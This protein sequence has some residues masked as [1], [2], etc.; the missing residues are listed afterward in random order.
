MVSRARADGGRSDGGR[1]HL[2]RPQQLRLTALVPLLALGLW[3]GCGFGD[4]TTLSR[5]RKALVVG[6]VDRAR[7]LVSGSDAVPADLSRVLVS[8]VELDGE[9]GA[10]WSV[11]AGPILDAVSGAY[12]RAR[13]DERAAIDSY[14]SDRQLRRTR[15]AAAA[16]DFAVERLVIWL[17]GA[18]EGEL[19][20]D[21][22]TAV[23]VALLATR[24]LDPA[25]ARRA[26]VI[27]TR[28]GRAATAPLAAAVS[29]DD[30]L[31]RASAV[32][33]LSDLGTDAALAAILPLI[34]TE[35][36]F[37]PLYEM[38]MALGRFGPG[39]AADPR[40]ALLALRDDSSHAT[41]S[42]PARALAMAQLGRVLRAAPETRA[43]GIPVVI[44]GL[45]DEHLYVRTRAASILTELRH[46]AVAQ[47]LA[48]L[49]GGWHDHPLPVV[50]LLQPSVEAEARVAL[51]KV[52]SETLMTLAEPTVMAPGERDGLVAAL[53]EALADEVRRPIAVGA[54][55]GLGPAGAEALYPLLDSTDAGVRALV[56]ETLAGMGEDAS[57]ARIV[58][59]ITREAEAEPLTAMIAALGALDGAAVVATV[60]GLVDAAQ[61]R[62]DVLEAVATAL[63]NALEGG[64]DAA[65]VAST[66]NVLLVTAT[67]DSARE[68]LRR[69]AIRALALLAPDGVENAM[70]DIMLSEHATPLIRKSAAAALTSL[71]SR[72][73][74]ALGAMEEILHIRRE[75]PD[76]FLKRLRKRHGSEAALN[77]AWGQMGWQTG[78]GN[79]RE[80][81]V[82]P[83]ILRAEV[84]RSVHTLRGA[85]AADLLA[86]VL[87]DDQSASVR[88]AAASRL[89]GAPA[90]VDALL[91]ALRKDDSGTVRAAC[92]V[93]L[94]EM[95]DAR[96]EGALLR[97]VVRDDYEQA[98][99]QAAIA[100]GVLGGAHAAKELSALLIADEDDEDDQLTAALTGDIAHALAAIGDAATPHLLP[101]LRHV[102][103]NVRHAVVRVLATSSLPTASAALRTVLRDDPSA[104]VRQAAAAHGPLMSAEAIDALISVVGNTEEWGAVRAEAADS[105]GRLGV[106]KAE[107]TLEAGLADAI[108]QVRAACATALGELH[109]DEAAGPLAKLAQNTS[110]L[111]LV[112]VAAVQA[113]GALGDVAEP[114]LLRLAAEEV[115][116][117][118][119]AAVTALTGFG[120]P[121]ASEALAAIAASPVEPRALRNIATGN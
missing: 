25:I 63:A 8:A 11:T 71:G 99:R 85:R 66:V 13:S 32:R 74:I 20:S 56:A 36:E 107:G 120:S 23:D 53:Q 27:V 40:A 35:T 33:W 67:S 16:A 82:I 95:G 15:A 101:G 109:S 34:G 10:D 100:L 49:G 112:R 77:A 72:A 81:K 60:D 113:L 46:E 41:P 80:V 52:A 93:A 21:P 97:V 83:S 90:H 70:R 18:S 26:R 64:A 14:V 58:A 69:A 31:I 54:L 62:P 121:A 102:D 117:V 37:E 38:P 108:P 86:E 28:L 115:G 43:A 1:R 106:S 91:R 59:V 17:D 30:P 92:A 42:G 45:T 103:P 65:P 118:R 75:D 5:A 98:R 29:H 111:S 2:T 22:A 79:F 68:D 88:A 96:A 57:A 78:F 47:L 6:D 76:D 44:A 4:D 94:G 110:E 87:R 24:S 73:D 19:L 7:E 51:Y 55:A 39:A 84:V 48:L 116:A 105:L 61:G 3:A 104:R 9:P 12:Q 114:A 50:S 119:E 89:S